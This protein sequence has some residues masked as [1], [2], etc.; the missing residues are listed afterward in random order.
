[1]IGKMEEGKEEEKTKYGAKMRQKQRGMQKRRRRRRN[2]RDKKIRKRKKGMG[3][4]SVEMEVILLPAKGPASPPAI[5]ILT[6]SGGLK[7]S[8]RVL[9]CEDGYTNL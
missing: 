9:L 8:Q 2:K 6:P 7:A 1:M 5:Q 3:G 4:V